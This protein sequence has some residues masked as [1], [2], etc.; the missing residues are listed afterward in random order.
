MKTSH[1]TSVVFFPTK[2][3]ILRMDTLD[4]KVVASASVSIPET[5]LENGIVKDTAGLASLIKKAFKETHITERSIAVMI[6]EFATYNK[7]LEIP[8]AAK[9]D[10]DEAVRWQ[11]REFLPEHGDQMVLDWKITERTS[12]KIT[13]LAV[14]VR[15]DI[16]DGYIDAVSLAG[17]MPLAVETPAIAISRMVPVTEDY[18]IAVF[19][20][21]SQ[22]VMLA[23]NK[24]KILASTMITSLDAKVCLSE[25]SRMVAHLGNISVAHI[26]LGGRSVTQ[27]FATEI[28]NFMK[29]SPESLA[30]AVIADATVANEYL[31]A[32]SLGKKDPASPSNESTVNLLPE[33]WVEHFRKAIFQVKAW[34][35]TLTISFVMWALFLSVVAS[36]MILSSRLQAYTDQSLSKSQTVSSEVLSHVGAAN[37]IAAQV[38]SIGAAT[39][40]PFEVVNLVASKIEPGIVLTAFNI[41]IET[42]SVEIVGTADSREK[43]LSFKRALEADTNFTGVSTPLASLLT[44]GNTKIAIVAVYKP[45]APVSKSS[46]TIQTIPVNK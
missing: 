28:S 21:E 34:T 40:Q 22:G 7:M 26:Y 37:Q 32:I 2:F 15:N 9:T 3:Q 8:T 10:L 27:E 31:L 44:E 12:S 38:L 42:G 39:H 41:N 46:G 35:L 14:A 20:D 23:M 33:I 1:F 11:M 25:L 6:P 13:L 17:L 24:G 4:K 30:P 5:L 43:L 16:L 29:L 36:Y 18:S 45:Y 19:L